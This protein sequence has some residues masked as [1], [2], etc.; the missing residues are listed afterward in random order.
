MK[1]MSPKRALYWV[2]ANATFT[3][4]APTAAQLNTALGG[5]PKAWNLSAAI[6]EGVNIGVTASD[7]PTRR[8]IVDKGNAQQRGYG[9]YEGLVPFG[10][11]G[12]PTT[13]TTSIFL[14]AFDLFK[15]KDRQGWWVSRIGYEY[16]VAP[17]AG[18]LVTV[19]GFLSGWPR[20]V[21]TDDGGPIQFTVP[22]YRTGEMT[23]NVA[24]G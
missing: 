23:P 18:Q 10:R 22:F 21:V 24:L 8:T 1:M 16:T 9:N 13:N 12:D 5:T 4:A 3:V 20:D 15:L 19:L 2:D 6:L 7:K 14:K 17:A 11:E